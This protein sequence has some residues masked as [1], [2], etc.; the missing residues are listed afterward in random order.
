MFLAPLDGSDLAE[1]VLA[2]VM[3]IA[4]VLNAEVSLCMLLRGIAKGK[5]MLL[6]LFNGI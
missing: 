5:W 1:C 3:S 2:H 6:I 4:L